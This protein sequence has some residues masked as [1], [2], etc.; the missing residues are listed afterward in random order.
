MW[1]LTTRGFFSAVQDDADQNRIIVRARVREDLDRLSEILPGL[2]PWHDPTADYAWRALI[3]R[4]EWGYALGVMA[5]EIDYRNFK[6]AVAEQQGTPR[7]RLYS[8]IWSVL[9]E[10]QQR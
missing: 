5:G 10:L 3:R 6:N 7:A 2:E 4:A 9:Y 8:R 1:L